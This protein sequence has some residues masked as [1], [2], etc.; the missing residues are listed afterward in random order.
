MRCVL[1]I[2]KIYMVLRGF[3]VCVVIIVFDRIMICY[4][5]D[6]VWLFDCCVNG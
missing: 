2:G 6:I 1:D 5:I 3:V 4:V